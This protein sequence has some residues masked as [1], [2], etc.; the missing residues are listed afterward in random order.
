M[1]VSRS[2]AGPPPLPFFCKKAR[3]G[4]YL[5]TYDRDLCSEVPPSLLR[6]VAG[7]SRCKSP[8]FCRMG[9]KGLSSYTTKE[10]LP[11][12]KEP[13]FVPKVQTNNS[14]AHL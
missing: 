1:W 8:G 11:N 2:H 7:P 14:K 6:T 3:F 13:F 12:D 10:E 4:T 5:R 9:G